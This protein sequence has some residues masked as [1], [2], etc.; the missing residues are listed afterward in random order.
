MRRGVAGGGRGVEG[1]SGVVSWRERRGRG[2]TEG[3]G[4]VGQEGWGCGGGGG[5]WRDRKG[6]GLE[7]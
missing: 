5:G 1:W 3:T 7:G 4:G 6:S 2:K